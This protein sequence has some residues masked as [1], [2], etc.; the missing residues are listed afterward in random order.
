MRK[1]LLITAAAAF[2]MCC[3]A[4]P[5]RAG[6][7]ASSLF[8][9]QINQLTDDSLEIVYK[10][11][12][13]TIETGPPVATDIVVG[14]VRYHAIQTQGGGSTVNFKFGN[15]L[16]PAAA[17]SAYFRLSISAVNPVTG[18]FSLAPDA[19]FQATYGSGAMA[20]VFEDPAATLNTQVLAKG[21][22]VSTYVA[23]AQTGTLQ[24]VV[25]FTG[26]GGAAASGEGWQ[27]S[28]IDTVGD[29]SIVFNLN[30]VTSNALSASAE[31]A[32]SSVFLFNK[33]ESSG[34]PGGSNTEFKFVNGGQ[35]PLSPSSGLPFTAHNN[36]SV[37]FSPIVVPEPSSMV[38]AGIALV[39]MGGMTW[40]RR[41]KA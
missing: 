14:V 30:L 39:S 3:Q 28:P 2:V 13:T 9:G 27:V 35:T 19:T 33:S 4:V 21:G 7:L 12:G 23:D 24:A 26:A 18:A 10:S 16:V 6:L 25:G 36:G 37:E 31:L 41:R 32:N 1:L 29:A 5:A 11:D 8:S 20:A 22:A 15:N 40:L 34:F 38:L 17:V